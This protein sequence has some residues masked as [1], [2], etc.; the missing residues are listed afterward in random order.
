MAQPSTW[1]ATQGTNLSCNLG[2]SPAPGVSDVW[3][4]IGFYQKFE[5]AAAPEAVEVRSFFGNLEINEDY[6][7][8]VHQGQE[9]DGA[10]ESVDY[11]K[12]DIGEF[13][14]RQGRRGPNGVGGYKT[15]AANDVCLTP[16]ECNDYDA[17][18]NVTAFDGVSLT[19][20]DHISIVDS[21][22]EQV[23]CCTLEAQ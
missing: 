9:A 17:D 4:R 20:G 12:G 1:D 18:G 8:E 23:A 13:L 15:N 3:G 14:T 5:S 11:Y 2:V 16:N 19:A 6:F 22:G 10:C 21:Y 7:I